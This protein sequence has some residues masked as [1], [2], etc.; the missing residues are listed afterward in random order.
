MENALE[1]PLDSRNAALD[2][3]F[4][5]N[6]AGHD[7]ELDPLVHIGQGARPANPVGIPTALGVAVHQ[8]EM[9]RPRG[10][11]VGHQS[12]AESAQRASDQIS[13]IRIE[14][15]PHV[16]DR[17]SRIVRIRGSRQNQ[18][19][20]VL[21]GGHQPNSLGVVRIGKRVDG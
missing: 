11:Q 20:L 7:V 1:R 17:E 19:S 15:R 10:H 14:Q 16:G 5:R 2:V 21:A 6:V 8:G 4:H 13:S 9:T 18:L 3:V 12:Q